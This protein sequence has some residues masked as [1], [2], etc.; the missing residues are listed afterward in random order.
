MACYSIID[1]QFVCILFSHFVFGFISLHFISFH[2]IVLVFTTLSPRYI[3][4]KSLGQITS[5]NTYVRL[6]PLSLSRLIKEVKFNTINAMQ[7]IWALNQFTNTQC[8]W[9]HSTTHGLNAQ[10]KSL[11]AV[12]LMNLSL[13]FS[14]QKDRDKDMCRETAYTGTNTSTQAQNPNMQQKPK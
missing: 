7:C 10:Y 12:A 5:Q 11:R 4:N 2:E 8:Q 14:G 6:R 9:K 13:S 3:N 1:A